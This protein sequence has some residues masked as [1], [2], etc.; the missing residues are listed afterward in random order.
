MIYKKVLIQI[1]ELYHSKFKANFENDKLFLTEKDCKVLY[2][3][4]KDKMTQNNR[5]F[6]IKSIKYISDN[7]SRGY[8]ITLLDD[9]D[10]IFEFKFIV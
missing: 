6:K 7:N 8:F 1:E 5:N 10:F 9:D 3:S 4:I 2:D